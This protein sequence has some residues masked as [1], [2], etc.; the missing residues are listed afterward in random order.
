[1]GSGLVI[2]FIEHLYT[3][4]ITASKYS[5]ITNL[6]TL[7]ITRAYAK[8]SQSAF[9]SS[10]LV[11]QLNSGD[12]S[13]YVLTLLLSPEYPMTDSLLQLSHL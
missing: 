2:G 1:M 7:E 11:M 6:R 8:S 5:A 10:F 13:A 3:Q 9:T 4:L 12:S